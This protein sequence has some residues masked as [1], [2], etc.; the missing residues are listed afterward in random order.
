MTSSFAS[1]L[2]DAQQFQRRLRRLS[3]AT[4]AFA[5]ASRSTQALFETVVRQVAESLNA[6][7]TLS[8]LTEDAS[9]FTTV[10]AFASQAELH[11]TLQALVSGQPKPV[12]SHPG[13]HYVVSTG[14]ALF[15]PFMERRADVQAGAP[16]ITQLARDLQVQSA[17][18]VPLLEGERVIGALGVARQGPGA[19]AF[20]EDDLTVAQTL[21]QHAA[22]ALASAR[23]FEQAARDMAEKELLEARLRAS[24]A[25]ES[26]ALAA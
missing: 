1:T 16:E 21:A 6:C 23:V 19:A 24:A 8:L 25:A 5:Q 7:C 4:H 14:T 18:V 20:E 26:A 22:L 13:I 9:H 12:E 2:S 15:A 17:L 11:R 3:N 10:S